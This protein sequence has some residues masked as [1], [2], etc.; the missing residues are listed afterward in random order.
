MKAR[1]CIVLLLVIGASLLLS[2]AVQG[3]SNAPT[4]SL[5]SNDPI[6][7]TKADRLDTQADHIAAPISFTPT[8]TTFLP[9]VLKNYVPCTGVPSLLSPDN[10]SN[11]DTLA[12]L[13]QWR[14]SHAPNANRLKLQVAL[15]SDFNQVVHA[16]L[17][18]AQLGDNDQRFSSNL[19]EATIYHWRAFL[20]CDEIEGTYSEVRSFTAGSG[21]TLPD[22]PAL[23][24]PTNG[25]TLA[26]KSATFEW[27]AVSGAQEYVLSFR[28]TGEVWSN[29]VWVS[30]TEHTVSWLQ[31]NTLY[32]WW[33]SA[34]NDYGISADSSTWQ[35]TTG[36][37]CSQATFPA[38]ITTV[39]NQGV[40]SI[41]VD[42]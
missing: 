36:A 31:P 35:F 33:V 6:P 2:I 39:F 9:T 25:S 26:S 30:G 27:A 12:P 14:I 4:N 1:L 38:Q 8:V 21:G 34:R 32:D 5:R 22:L 13:F 10:G 19:Q 29:I 7:H 11:L 15:D 16:A 42:R 40:T 24:A 18:G 37:S 17:T 28:P 20:L 3:A 41:S 23:L